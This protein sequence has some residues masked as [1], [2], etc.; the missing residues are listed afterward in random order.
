MQ[1]ARAGMKSPSARGCPR[2]RPAGLVADALAQRRDA[3][4]GSDDRAAESA[5]IRSRRGQRPR[6]ASGSPIPAGRSHPT[7]TTSRLRGATLMRASPPPSLVRARQI[8]THM[9]YLHPAGDRT[10][11]A[12]AWRSAHPSST[13]SCSSTLARRPT[14]SR[15]GWPRPSPPGAGGLVHRL[16]LP[17]HHRGDRRSV[18][19]GLVGRSCAKLTSRPGSRRT[20]AA[21][22]THATEEFTAAVERLRAR[23]MTPAAMILDCAGHQRPHRPPRPFPRSRPRAAD[24][25]RRRVVDR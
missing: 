13:P 19:G 8:N 17:R 24:P 3:A 12:A 10:R 1:D 22:T 7:P 23:G 16:C 21:A 20:P 5:T 11:R 18:A 25:A 2:P 15:G 9:R 6:G 14:T 4:F